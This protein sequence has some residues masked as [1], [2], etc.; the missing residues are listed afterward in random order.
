MVQIQ[1]TGKVLAKPGNPPQRQLGDCSDPIYKRVL[2]KPG[3][4][5]NGSWGIV[6]IQPTERVLAKP[7]NPPNGSW[8]MVQILPSLQRSRL[9]ES[10]Q[11][12]F[13]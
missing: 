2:A 6:Q 3:N 7:G 10:A 8:G 13:D 5:P 12:R 9:F 4:P 11:P 1:P